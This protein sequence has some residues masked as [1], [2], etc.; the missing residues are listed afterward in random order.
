MPTKTTIATT[1]AATSN[2]TAPSM[3]SARWSG[4]GL[5][6][7]SSTCDSAGFDRDPLARDDLLRRRRLLDPADERGRSTCRFA[8][9]HLVEPCHAGVLTGGGSGLVALNAVNGY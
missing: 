3:R 7:R 2:D 4:Q 9:G 1:T 8:L 6:R 5:R